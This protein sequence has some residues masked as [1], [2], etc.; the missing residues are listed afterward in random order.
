M[1]KRFKKRLMRFCA[2][3]LLL[4]L[5]LAGCTTQTPNNEE[6]EAVGTP[7]STTSANPILPD[8]ADQIAE[9]EISLDS[10]MNPM[11]LTV[12]SSGVAYVGDIE[13]V[14]KINKSDEPVVFISGLIRCVGVS[15]V[16]DTLYVFDAREDLYLLT[17]DLQGTRRDEQVVILDENLKEIYQIVVFQNVPVAYISFVGASTAPPYLCN[18]V[19]KTTKPLPN[20]DEYNRLNPVSDG[21][22]IGASRKEFDKSV[23]LTVDT[24]GGVTETLIGRPKV[25][26]HVYDVAA[27]LEYVVDT[28]NISMINKSE[29]TFLRQNPCDKNFIFAMACT[30]GQFYFL[31]DIESERKLVR[32]DVSNLLD[33]EKRVLRIMQTE[34]DS[35]EL[36]AFIRY[37]QQKHPEIEIRYVTTATTDRDLVRLLSGEIEVDIIPATESKYI[38]YHAGLARDLA[39][40]PNIVAALDNPQLLEGVKENS[41]NPD[42]TIFGVPSRVQYRGYIVNEALFKKLRLTPPTPDWTVDDYYQLAKTVAGLRATGAD[43]YLEAKVDM[44]IYGKPGQRLY[45]G[46]TALPEWSGLNSSNGYAVRIDTP[47]MVEYVKKSREIYELF[48]FYNL[49]PHSGDDYAIAKRGENILLW[50][51]RVSDVIDLLALRTPLVPENGA[52]PRTLP[53]PR[54]MYGNRISRFDDYLAIYAKAQNSQDAALFI[55]EFLDEGY[56]FEHARSMWLFRDFSRYEN[57]AEIRALEPLIAEVTKGAA[58]APPMYRLS[59]DFYTLT[60]ALEEQYFKDEFTPAQY[61]QELQKTMERQI[62]G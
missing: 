44:T 10:M 15:A 11:R 47:E 24:E 23:V 4:S 42:G 57:A 58:D 8:Y 27:E 17:Y 62:P 55:A 18:L 38:Y 39:Q 13:T 52:S 32:L 59:Q 5:L 61:V 6:T 50:D 12:D 7:V 30:D 34:F 31:A 35:K 43:V 48:P 2:P 46:L 54:D 3:L 36:D 21:R 41:M 26:D 45:T 40:F 22:I 56:Q 37:F 60:L 25:G 49:T 20:A 16:G 1:T 28:E 51:I 33:H 19:T 29:V 9:V 14:Y 53:G